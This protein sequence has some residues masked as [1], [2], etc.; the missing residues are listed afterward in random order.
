MKKF[1]IILFLFGALLNSTIA[2]TVQG[3]I[4][5][6]GSNTVTVVAKPSSAINAQVGNF[7]IVISIADQTALGGNP[8]DA[9]IT[10]TILS[11]NSKIDNGSIVNPVVMNGRAYYTYL[12]FQN[13]GTDANT[14]WTAN[15]DN[16]VISFTFPSASYIPTVQLN[17]LTSASGGSNGQMYWYVQFNGLGD[18]T[19]YTTPFYG[20]GAVNGSTAEQF[21]PLQGTTPVKFTSFY[22]L[23]KDNTAL[24]SWQI[25]NE[26][27]NVMSYEV[28]RSVNG[29]AFTKFTSVTPKHNGSVTNTYNLTDNNLSSVQNSGVI[30]YRIKQIDKNGNFVYTDIRS[31][32]ISAKGVVIGVYPNPVKEAANLSLDL[33]EDALITVNVTDA[34]GKEIKR[35]NFNATKGLNV[36]KIDMNTLASGTYLLKVQAGTDIKT[37]SVVKAN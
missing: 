12:I 37:I 3:S 29:V 14:S 10:K 34:T 22:A 27:A 17:D 5:D 4:I 35:L 31:V 1:I 25:T 28:E 7:N 2:Q 15:V 32:R 16:P 23:K 36:K 8:T 20:I 26:D 18:V 21:V 11:V 9:E 13:N 19:D 6:A 33:T 30:Y 24:L